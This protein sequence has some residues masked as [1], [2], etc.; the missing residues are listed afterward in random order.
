MVGVQLADREDLALAHGWP[1]DHQVEGAEL[2]GSGTQVVEVRLQLGGAAVGQGGHGAI[3]ADQGPGA[4]G[5]SRGKPGDGGP[6]S[7]PDEPAMIGP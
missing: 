6:W 5:D 2:R 4:L 1:A 7:G 3:L